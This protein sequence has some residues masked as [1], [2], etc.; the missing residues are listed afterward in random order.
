MFKSKKREIV[1]PQAEHSRLSGIV[2]NLWGNSSFD[3]PQFS[4]SSFVLGVTFHDRGYGELDNYPLGEL[5]EDVWLDIHRKSASLAYDDAS[6]ELVVQLQLIRL[7]SYNLTADRK[8]YVDERKKFVERL[9][10]DNALALE[11]YMWADHIT[12]FCDNI[13]F[14]FCFEEAKTSSVGVY[15]KHADSETA[16]VKYRI[17]EGGRVEIDPWPL[18]RDAVDTFIIGYNAAGYPERLQPTYIPVHLR[19]VGS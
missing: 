5:S 8:R 19:Q 15:R 1:I 4:R 13:S 3:A 14:D 18:S 12:H 10:E 2:A 17:A 11:A 6:A 7:V 16:E 9:A